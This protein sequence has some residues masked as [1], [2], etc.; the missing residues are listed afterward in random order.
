MKAALFAAWTVAEFYFHLGLLD[1]KQ[2][3]ALKSSEEIS[4]ASTTLVRIGLGSQA[5]LGRGV[6]PL[7]WTLAVGCRRV[8]G[9]WRHFA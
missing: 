8:V 4:A 9:G 2:P 1:A 3:P 5:E 6:R 7:E